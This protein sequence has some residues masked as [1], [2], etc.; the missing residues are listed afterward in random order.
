MTNSVRSRLF[1][2][3][4]GFCSKSTRLG[5]TSGDCLPSKPVRSR[6]FCFCHFPPSVRP[7][8]LKEKVGRNGRNRR[9]LFYTHTV[10]FSFRSFH[11]P[12]VPRITE[13][14]RE[15]TGMNGNERNFIITNQPKELLT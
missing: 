5:Q 1:S 6:P 13:N 12:S 11:I 15:R 14:E 4:L 9:V 7:F 2:D 10:L 3:F 8:L